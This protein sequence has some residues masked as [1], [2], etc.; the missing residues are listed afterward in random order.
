MKV[1]V[2]GSRKIVDEEKVFEILNNSLFPIDEVVSG[3]AKGIDQI[4]EMWAKSKG[5]PVTVFL[6]DYSDDPKRAPLLRNTAM[7]EYGDALVAVWDG[8]SS[9]TKHMIGE[10]GKVKKPVK[11]YIV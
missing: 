6:P 10:M 3:H 4:G 8:R 2:A 9:G 11:V 7:A 1:V 5:V